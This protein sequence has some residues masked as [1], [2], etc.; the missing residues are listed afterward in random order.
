MKKDFFEPLRGCSF[1][2]LAGNHD[3]FH[4]NTNQINALS[5]LL[6]GQGDIFDIW[7]PAHFTIGDKKYLFLPWINAENMEETKGAIEKSDADICVAHLE[8]AGFEMHAGQ[9][10]THGLDKSMFSKFKLVITGHFH[11][12]SRQD[13]IVYVGAP[14]EM[15]WNDYGCPRGF[16]I[17][18]TDT[19]DLE[20]IQNP[21][22]L[23]QRVVYN[24]KGQELKSL[25]EMIDRMHFAGVY[26]R[27]I[28]EEK[29]N[30]YWFDLFIAHLESKGLYDLKIIDQTQKEYQ[31][32]D[33]PDQTEGTLAT[34]SKAV[35]RLESVSVD[36]DALKNLFV[37]LYN[38]AISL[39]V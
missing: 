12:K 13:N 29:T 15:T 17:L 14:W 28:V 16:H 8:L 32:A 11:K 2:I 21:Y 23:F 19:L 33:A 24:D 39:E 31:I 9:L 34:I 27:V 22:S 26:C 6:D 37:G 20:F 36:K 10:C 4:K 18:D 5:E 7:S 38:R 1:T 30:P 35:D 25:L 3:V